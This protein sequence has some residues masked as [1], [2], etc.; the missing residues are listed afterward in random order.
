MT[1]D[2]IPYWRDGSLEKYTP[3]CDYVVLKFARWAFEKFR[4]VEDALGTQM[5]A[6]GEVMLSARLTRKPSRRLSVVSKTVVQVSALPRIS[7]RSPRKNF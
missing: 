1:L 6:V 4:G 3:S 7:T 5:K 2:Q